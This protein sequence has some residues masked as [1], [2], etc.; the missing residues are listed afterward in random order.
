MDNFDSIV[1]AMA[2]A[3]IAAET[4]RCW[5]HLSTKGLSDVDD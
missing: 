2:D 1:S 4:K 3:L 5:H